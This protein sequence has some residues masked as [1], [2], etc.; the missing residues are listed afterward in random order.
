MGFGPAAAPESWT[1][2]TTADHLVI[3][4]DDDR[5]V[6]AQTPFDGEAKT[7]FSTYWPVYPDK[8][9]VVLFVDDGKRIRVKRISDKLVPVKP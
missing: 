3:A 8:R 4:L 7:F 5:P 9:A 1:A 2:P 6:P